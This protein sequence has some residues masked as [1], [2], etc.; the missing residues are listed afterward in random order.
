MP[1]S[2][3]TQE[4]INRLNEGGA[5]QKALSGT[6][7]PRAPE[8]GSRH[9]PEPWSVESDTVLASYRIVALHPCGEAI[10]VGRFFADNRV[11]DRLGV[12]SRE[13][14]AN[15]R[16]AVAC[17]NACAEFSPD[18]EL[19]TERA[20]GAAMRLLRN[21]IVALCTDCVDGEP[22]AGA[23]GEL[24]HGPQGEDARPCGAEFVHEA[25]RSAS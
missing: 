22:W 21:C 19:L 23:L 1:D 5:G 17:V 7:T 2:K 15:A 12:T 16:R 4:S 11:R 6:G 25:I 13:D 10:G 9:T 3:Q 24:Y 18:C 20:P 8:Q 14:R